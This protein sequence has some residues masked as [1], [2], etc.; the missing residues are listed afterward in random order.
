MGVKYNGKLTDSWSVGVLV[1]SLIENRLPFDLP[2]LDLLT[3]SGVSPS[4]I[5]RRRLRNNPAHR[6]AMIDWEWV[7]VANLDPEGC[8]FVPEVKLIISD[9]KRV[10]DVLLVR[11]DKRVTIGDLIESPEFAWIKQSLPSEFYE[12]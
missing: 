10:A 7:L 6:I 3:N 2:P 12:F 9:L 4:V 5:K 11:K 8:Q 1:Y